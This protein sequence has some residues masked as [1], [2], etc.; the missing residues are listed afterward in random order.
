MQA[1]NNFIRINVF[2]QRSLDK[3][4]PKGLSAVIQFQYCFAWWIIALW[5]LGWAQILNWQIVDRLMDIPF[6]SYF[7]SRWELEKKFRR[8][9]WLYTV[10]L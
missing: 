2:G 7:P 5:V 1:M 10:I 6:P 8:D 9:E 4:P 3:A